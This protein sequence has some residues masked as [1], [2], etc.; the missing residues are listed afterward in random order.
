MLACTPPEHVHWLTLQAPVQYV[1]G[2]IDGTE[3]IWTASMTNSESIAWAE[4]VV[5]VFGGA[6]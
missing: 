1:M 4:C 3:L 6:Q 5:R 2:W